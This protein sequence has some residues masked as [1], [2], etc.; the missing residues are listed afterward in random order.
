VWSTIAVEVTIAGRFSAEPSAVSDSASESFRILERTIRSVVPDAMVAP[1]LV[2]VVTDARY[3]S[4][5]SRNVFRFLPLR[6]TPRDLARMHGPNERIGIREYETAIR[7]Y[8]QIVLE[9]T[10]NGR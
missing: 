3:Y 7:I 8:R 4:D 2:V 9:L 10:S 1:Y 6:L 5:L